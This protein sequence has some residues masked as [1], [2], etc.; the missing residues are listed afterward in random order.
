MENRGVCDNNTVSWGRIQNENVLENKDLS[1]MRMYGGNREVREPQNM[2]RMP[3]VNKDEEKVNLGS[4]YDA[5]LIGG[6]MYDGIMGAGVL[7]SDNQNFVRIQKGNNICIG[8]EK[9][10][11]LSLEKEDEWRDKSELGYCDDNERSLSE[12]EIDKKIIRVMNKNQNVRKYNL[13]IKN[14]YNALA[15]CDGKIKVIKQECDKNQSILKYET[16]ATLEELDRELEKF[17]MAEEIVMRIIESVVGEDPQRIVTSLK[18][19][20]PMENENLEYQKVKKQKL[21]NLQEDLATT[22]P[23]PVRSFLNKLKEAWQ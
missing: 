20:S 18:R 2:V 21:E 5:K 1:G 19:K 7:E 23:A 11:P 22:T 4:M 3:A 6:E 12:S 16:P 10:E 8:G 15:E 13:R 14:L 17:D 9:P